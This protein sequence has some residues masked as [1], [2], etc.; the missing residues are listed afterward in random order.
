MDVLLDPSVTDV[1]FEPFQARPPL[2]YNGDV[3]QDPQN[4]RNSLM[5]QFYHKNSVAVAP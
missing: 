5:S 2:L 3:T 4:W 1:L